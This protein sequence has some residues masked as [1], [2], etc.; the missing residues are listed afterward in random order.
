MVCLSKEDS[1]S[2]PI[3]QMRTLQ[4]KG[5]I[6]ISNSKVRRAWNKIRGLQFLPQRHFL[7]LVT[8]R[9]SES[10][11]MLSLRQM[12]DNSGGLETKPKGNTQV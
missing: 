6:W 1:D 8:T 7:L 2:H 3:Q 4:I 10:Q 5:L 11:E 9:H 12:E